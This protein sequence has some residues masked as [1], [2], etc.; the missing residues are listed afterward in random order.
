[1]RKFENPYL[2]PQFIKS[3]LNVAQFLENLVHAVLLGLSIGL[4]GNI[5]YI[6]LRCDRSIGLPL[7]RIDAAQIALREVTDASVHGDF[8]RPN[9]LD[10]L[11][12]P[13][14]NGRRLHVRYWILEILRCRRG[15]SGIVLW[16]HSVHL[17]GQ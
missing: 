7:L 4:L 16:K 12:K 8:V 9:F 5:Q 11:N 15:E 17:V 13:P 14:S 6:T 2:R 1:M 10:G 3:L